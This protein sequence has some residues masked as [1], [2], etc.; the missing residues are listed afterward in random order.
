LLSELAVQAHLF[1]E[2][3]IELPA[4]KQHQELSAEFAKP[5]HGDH[6]MPSF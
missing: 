6:P 2:I 3:S 1:F 5:I 4:P